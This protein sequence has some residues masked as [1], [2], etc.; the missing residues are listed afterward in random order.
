MIARARCRFASPPRGSPAKIV[1]R[2]ATHPHLPRPSLPLIPMN[3]VL[4]PLLLAL[5][6]A[7]ICGST[8]RASRLES[9]DAAD[10]PARLLAA[11]GVIPVASAGPYVERG[12]ARITVIAKLGRPD[13][14]AAGRHVVVPGLPGE[15][16]RRRRRT[17]PSLSPG[18]RDQPWPDHSGASRR[19]RRV[20]AFGL[21]RTSRG[22]AAIA[23]IRPH[24]AATKKPQGQSPAAKGQR[25][26][27]AERLRSIFRWCRPHLSQFL[28]AFAASTQQAW[29]QV[30][31]SFSA[32]VQQP[33]FLPAGAGLV[34]GSANAQAT[35]K[36]EPETR[37]RR[38]RGSFI[39][40]TSPP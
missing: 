24:H 37:A 12:S 2:S 19:A 1:R 40:S 25:S 22:E 39:G 10:H 27:E 11:H 16:E 8:A 18:S 29:P 5:T 34:A 21:H 15:G 4:R 9:I 23:L 7:L 32:L 3:T 36:I 6:L 20:R 30:L 17:R 31:P 13:R 38:S 14:T 33:P 26:T 28:P 35:A